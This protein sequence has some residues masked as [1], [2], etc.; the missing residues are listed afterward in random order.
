MKLPLNPLQASSSAPTAA[1]MY[2]DL[3]RL[4]PSELAYA[5]SHRASAYLSSQIVNLLDLPKAQKPS[6]ALCPAQSPPRAQPFPPGS[7][8]SRTSLP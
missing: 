8:K 1:W 6:R 3:S 7:H 5:L 4:I 2:D